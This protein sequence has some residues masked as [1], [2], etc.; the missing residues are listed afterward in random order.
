MFEG[1]DPRASEGTIV[2]QSLALPASDVPAVKLTAKFTEAPSPT[3][4]GE[5]TTLLTGPV[6]V[7]IV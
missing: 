3:L 5:A 6:G 7:P 2:T 4:L 1:V